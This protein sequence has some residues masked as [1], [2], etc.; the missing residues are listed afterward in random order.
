MSVFL[1]RFPTALRAYRIVRRDRNADVGVIKFGIVV[2]P[3]V[4]IFFGDFTGFEFGGLLLPCLKTL[5]QIGGTD[6]AVKDLCSQADQAVCIR[7]AKQLAILQCE[8]RVHQ[9]VH[10]VDIGHSNG[11]GRQ[12]KNDFTSNR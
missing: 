9:T 2:A 1:F 3:A 6:S 10:G 12:K 5:L 4:V 11:F 7:D 8:K